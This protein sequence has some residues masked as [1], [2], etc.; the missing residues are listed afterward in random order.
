[1]YRVLCSSTSVLPSCL[2]EA[3]GRRGANHLQGADGVRESMVHN[4]K[5]QRNRVARVLQSED[6]NG[7]DDDDDD[8]LDDDDADDA[9][10]D[11]DDVLQ[12]IFSRASCGIVWLT[13]KTKVFLCTSSNILTRR[14]RR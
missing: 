1:M 3:H 4:D 2:A 13:P 14:R 10:D 12:S 8:D 6:E 5:Y 11:H 7:D 9:D